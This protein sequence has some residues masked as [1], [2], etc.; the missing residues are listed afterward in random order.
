MK[1]LIF[2]LFPLITFGQ[3]KSKVQWRGLYAGAQTI[4]VIQA[5]QQ[6]S[7]SVYIIAIV[8]TGRLNANVQYIKPIPYSRALIK[9]GIDFKIL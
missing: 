6:F 8:G 5:K 7:N 4:S 1:T 2:L 9:F 3:K